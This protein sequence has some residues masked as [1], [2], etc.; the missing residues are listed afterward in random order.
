MVRL[1]QELHAA[2]PL[3]HELLCVAYPARGS[4]GTWDC[5]RQATEAGI[6]VLVRRAR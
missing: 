4:R 5:V 1:A 3:G 2:A 6:P